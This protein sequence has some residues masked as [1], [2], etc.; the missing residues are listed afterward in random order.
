MFYSTIILN[1]NGSPFYRDADLLHK[2]LWLCYPQ[3]DKNDPSNIASF[4]DHHFGHQNRRSTV[5]NFMYVI[6][7]T[8]IGFTVFMQSASK[9]NLDGALNSIREMVISAQTAFRELS[10]ERGQRLNYL[11][12]FNPMDKERR[13]VSAV[14]LFSE[15]MKQVCDLH[16]CSTKLSRVLRVYKQ[17]V[18]Q[19]VGQG[20]PDY[21]S[22]HQADLYGELTVTNPELFTKFVVQGVGRSKTYGCGLLCLKPLA[23]PKS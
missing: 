6:H 12:R 18:A 2:R 7:S 15:R 4:V 5:S 13:L 17:H 22:I 23:A 14:P 16:S 11:I 10:F 1:R 20:E 21:F 8:P 19:T 9:P 3:T